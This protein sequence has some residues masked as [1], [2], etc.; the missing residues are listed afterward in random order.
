MAQHLTRRHSV[1]P[2]LAIDEPKLL[3]RDEPPMGD[4]HPVERSVKIGFPEIQEMQKLREFGS[5][6]EVLPDIALQQ[7]RVVRQSV[8]DLCSGQRK[9]F[10]LVQQGGLRHRRP[11]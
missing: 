7:S 2:E 11:L 10:E 5:E 9:S 3:W 8:E 4:A 1:Q 6:V